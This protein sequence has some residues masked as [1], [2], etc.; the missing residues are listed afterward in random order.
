MFTYRGCYGIVS[1]LVLLQSQMLHDDRGR[2]LQ[3][4]G[5]T[6]QIF[7]VCVRGSS[8]VLFTNNFG[9]LRIMREGGG[10]VI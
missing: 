2:L 5:E 8:N 6:V 7:P 1:V 10:G 9:V 4:F 3:L